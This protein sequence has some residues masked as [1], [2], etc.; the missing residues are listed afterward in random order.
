MLRILGVSLLV[1][2]CAPAS[3][4]VDALDDQIVR[5]GWN[6]RTNGTDLVPVTIYAPAMVTSPAAAVV[7]VQGGGVAPEL[8]AWQAVELARR[9]YIVA[10]PR[11]PNDLAFFAADFGQT[12][13]EALV[14]PAARGV[15]G[16]RLQGLVDSSRIAVAGHSLGGVV[17][18]KLA[19]QGSFAAAMAQ[20]SFPDTADDAKVAALAMPTLS[21]AGETD[22]QATLPKVHA[23]WEKLPSPTALVT[24]AGVSHFQFT[25]D[26]NEDARRKCPGSTSLEDAHARMLEAMT[27]FLSTALAESK[28]IDS[29]RLSTISGATVEAR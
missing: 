18:F 29:V 21:L 4:V 14:D 5:I 15:D 23:G 13:R 28:S 10:M 6:L 22:C 20:A 27:V 26:G 25:S 17:T 9:G 2:S 11:H 7:Y 12:A 1:T 16:S 24:F 3:E 19:T 8:Y